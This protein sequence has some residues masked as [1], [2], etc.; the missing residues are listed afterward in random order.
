MR[1]VLTKTII[2]KKLILICSNLTHKI[3][4]HVLEIKLEF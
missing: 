3:K 2:F 1:V 4:N